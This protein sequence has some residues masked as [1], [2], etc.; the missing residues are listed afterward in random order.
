MASRPAA[1]PTPR[2]MRAPTPALCQVLGPSSCR[3]S[4]GGAVRGGPM[5]TFKS[6]QPADAMLMCAAFAHAERCEGAPSF[7]AWPCT[8]AKVIGTSNTK[9]IMLPNVG[10]TEARELTIVDPVEERCAG[11]RHRP[12]AA[13]SF[14]GGWI[15]EGTVSVRRMRA[16]GRGVRCAW[17]AN[18]WNT[19]NARGVPVSPDTPH[20]GRDRYGSCCGRTLLGVMLP[21]FT[22]MGSRSFPA[23][24]YC[25]LPFRF[26]SRVL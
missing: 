6:E 12:G 7:W 13:C 16:R 19:S 15:G 11:T 20:F 21:T 10:S 14:M 23:P 17:P 2:P 5:G 9:R 4:S 3:G 22:R 1:H 8:K 25:T 24:V 18:G 26:T